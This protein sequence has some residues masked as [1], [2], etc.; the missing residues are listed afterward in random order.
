MKTFHL[1]GLFNS[2]K[3]LDNSHALKER[4]FIETLCASLGTHKNITMKVKPVLNC[5]KNSHL[6]VL[7]KC[8]ER[9]IKGIGELQLVI[10]SYKYGENNEIYKVI[11]N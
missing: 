1:K 3:P 11:S 6:K 5:G 4:T 8:T 2:P 7:G 9:L 10:K